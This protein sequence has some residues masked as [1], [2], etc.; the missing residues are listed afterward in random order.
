MTSEKQRNKGYRLPS[1]ID[2][3]PLTCV[4]FQ[5]PDNPFYRAAVRGAVYELSKWFNWEKSY[6]EGDTRARDAAEI[7]RTLLTETLEFGECTVF[8]IRLKPTD[9]CIIQ[10]YVDGAWTD[11]IDLSVCADN[12]ITSQFNDLFDNRLNDVFPPD[13]Q[14]GSSQ[15]GEQP[16][17][18]DPDPNECF[19]LDLTVSATGRTLIPL[20]IRSGWTLEFSNVKGAWRQDDATGAPWYCAQGN[21]FLLG[22]CQGNPVAADGSFPVPTANKFEL[23]LCYPGS[24]GVHAREG[25]SIEIPTGQPDGYYWLQIN[26]TDLTDNAGEVSVHV[27]ACNYNSLAWC[28]LFNNTNWPMPERWF[29]DTNGSWDGTYWQGTTTPYGKNL[30]LHVRF[31]ER[32]VTD[33]LLHIHRDNGQGFPINQVAFWKDGVEQL[34]STQFN[35]FSGDFIQPVGDD[36]LCDEIEIYIDTYVGNVYLIDC[37][38]QGERSN[39]FGEDNCP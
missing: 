23:V 33:V 11:A 20:P 30:N 35:G 28:K 4:R 38:I 6:T 17:G 27:L 32:M 19:E 21:L 5:I 24:G 16:G 29:V 22:T 10:K 3:Y 25:T 26:D 37:K 1:P 31:P 9:S 15:P 12:R 7:F 18:S 14:P 2:G 34:R 13:N 8:D 39:P 36:V